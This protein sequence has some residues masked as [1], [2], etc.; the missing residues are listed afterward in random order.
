MV[1]NEIFDDIL[2]Y[3]ISHNSRTRTSYEFNLP[4]RFDTIFVNIFNFD[5]EMSID[6]E[7][8]NSLNYVDASFKESSMIFS[9]VTKIVS[10]YIE[11]TSEI[12]SIKMIGDSPKKSEIYK[13]L[14]MQLGEDWTVTRK[15]PEVQAVKNSYS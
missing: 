13:K 12:H 3:E 9:T 14:A 1:L 8:N 4:E 11:K 5:G 7:V 10:E 15:G 6:F 2:D